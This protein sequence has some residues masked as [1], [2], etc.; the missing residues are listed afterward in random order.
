MWVF[1]KHLWRLVILI[2]GIFVFVVGL[3][4]IPLP[5]PGI[6]V[7]FAGLL[8]LATEFEWAAKHRDRAKNHLKKVLARAKEKGGDKK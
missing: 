5:G 2:V 1:A 4:L 3:I 8:I 6:L 7:C